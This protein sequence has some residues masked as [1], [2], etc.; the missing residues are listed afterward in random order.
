MACHPSVERCEVVPL[1]VAGHNLNIPLCTDFYAS[2]MQPG[3]DDGLYRA[4]HIALSE[5]GWRAGNQLMGGHGTPSGAPPLSH[6]GA[7]QR[8][9]SQMVPV[10]LL[11]GQSHGRMSPNWLPQ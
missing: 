10:G 9:W 8:S 6:Q 5:R 7:S 3:C 1:L 4:R 11:G 2:D